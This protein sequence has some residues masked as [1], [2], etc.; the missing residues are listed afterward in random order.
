MFVGNWFLKG[1][2]GGEKRRL[3]IGCELLTSPTLFFLDE[4]TS[5]L[6]AASAY[7]VMKGIRSLAEGGRTVISII[8]QPS[9][10]VFELFEKLC[11][12][13]NGKTG[14]RV[15]RALSVFLSSLVCSVFWRCYSCH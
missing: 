7:Y 15:C 1:I 3:S 5:G 6:D 8:H 10:E 14:Q 11:L 13:S 12:L 2:S 4:P 9:S